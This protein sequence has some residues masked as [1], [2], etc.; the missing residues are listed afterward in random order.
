MLFVLLVIACNGVTS[1]F[2]AFGVTK[3]GRRAFAICVGRIVC[4]CVEFVIH[5]RVA[6]SVV[7]MI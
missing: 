6:E 1:R 4:G 5:V 7:V 3:C 2:V